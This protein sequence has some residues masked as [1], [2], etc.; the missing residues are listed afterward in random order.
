MP[1]ANTMPRHGSGGA[2][3][4]LSEFC[5]TSGFPAEPHRTT[6]TDVNDGRQVG[7]PTKA[8]A[9]DS[10]FKKQCSAAHICY[11]GLH[12]HKRGERSHAADL[13]SP[14]A[15]TAQSPQRRETNR[16]DAHL[17]RRSIVLP[18]DSAISKVAPSWLLC[19]PRAH[20]SCL[21]AMLQKLD[22]RTH[23]PA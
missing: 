4:S 10:S 11:L 20:H 12:C 17:Y 22:D 14:E 23:A 18:H 7:P 9:F 2:G 6:S 21:A 19:E 15:F 13:L 8:F 3:V 16:V 1:A 5:C